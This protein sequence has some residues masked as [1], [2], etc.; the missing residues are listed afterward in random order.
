MRTGSNFLCTILRRFKDLRVLNE[1]FIEV[2]NP[3]EIPI[4]GH[5]SRHEQLKLFKKFAVENKSIPQLVEELNRNP[6]LTLSYID[7]LIPNY[8]VIKVHN[9]IFKNFNLQY[10]IDDPEC[11]FI[12]LNR[13]SKIKQFVSLEIARKLNIHS[14]ID[15]SQEKILVDPNIFLQFQHDSY[16]WYNELC[17]TLSSKNYLQ[18][19]YEEDLEKFDDNKQLIYSKI[20][21]WLQHNK[22]DLR[23]GLYKTN[24]FMKKQNLASLQDQ[25]INYQEI[26]HLIEGNND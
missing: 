26:K 20:I 7:E 17:Q 23:Q 18:I 19:N 13:S 11:I 3:K 15:T 5:F 22:I 9:F 2:T 6:K 16:E 14:K 8:K 1:L 4:E 25:I 12:V 21:R 10:M 24:F